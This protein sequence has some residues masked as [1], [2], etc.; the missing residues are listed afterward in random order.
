MANPAEVEQGSEEWHALRAQR[1]TGSQFCD[2]L[3][4]ANARASYAKQIVAA[5]ISGKPKI[6]AKAK[7]LEWGHANEPLAREAYEI[8]TGEFVEESGFIIHPRFD[9]VGVS[10][11]G[12]VGQLGTIEIKSPY[13]QAVHIETLLSG[14]PDEHKAQVQGGL[15][16][17]GRK[18]CDFISFDPRQAEPYQLYIERIHRDDV[19]IARLESH[20]LQF[21]AEVQGIVKKIEA[22]TAARHLKA[23]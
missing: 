9:F 11:D 17:T 13:D 14:M 21:W 6:Q 7:S 10:V 16:V 15:W 2:V 3:G 23:A 5:I 12:L 1:I 8:E 4:S 20:C 18:W 22:S 19:Y